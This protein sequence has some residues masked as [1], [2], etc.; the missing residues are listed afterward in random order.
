MNLSIDL[1]NTFAKTALF[2]NNILQ[3]TQIRL[4][5]EDL[6]LYVEK[7]SPKQII[8]SSVSRSED[9]LRDS[10]SPFCQKILVLSPQTPLPIHKVYDTPNTLG[11]DRLAAAIG[12]LEI[13]PESHCIVIDLG[14]CITYDWLDAD[15]SFRGG[16]IS[17][18]MKMRFRAMNSFTQRLP[19]VE[20][21]SVD[22]PLVGS[23][24]MACMQS[25][26]VNGLVSEINGIIAE[27]GQFLTN[28]NV[29]L[30]GGDAP[31]FESRLKMRNFVIPH[32]VH[33]G[34]NKILIYNES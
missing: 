21:P 28:F 3:E 30:T 4:S 32:L 23:N 18:G 9:E 8:V 31:F 22:V 25:G 6:L 34:L 5:F 14:T 7:T 33:V 29:V 26:V 20:S 24:T 11:A 13:F 19:L 1:G 2:D 12:A 15:G 16:I 17:P 27:Y 10:L